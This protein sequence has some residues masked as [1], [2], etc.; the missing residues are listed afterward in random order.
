MIRYA[1]ET[2]EGRVFRPNRVDDQTTIDWWYVLS[3]CAM[4]DVLPK[5]GRFFTD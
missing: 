4:T 3:R 1:L 2:I 5:T